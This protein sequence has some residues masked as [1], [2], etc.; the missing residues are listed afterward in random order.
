MYNARKIRT[1][2]K[3]DKNGMN[4]STS[5]GMERHEEERY[6]TWK[7]YNIWNKIC[8]FTTTYDIFIFPEEDI[9]ERLGHTY[10]LSGK[11]IYHVVV[12]HLFI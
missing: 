9:T 12:R 4:T 8:T 6:N 7:I 11:S 3:M 2:R 1:Q 10:L 5:E